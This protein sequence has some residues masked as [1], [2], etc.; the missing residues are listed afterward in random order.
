MFENINPFDLLKEEM[1]NDE[2][3]VRVNAIHRLKTVVTVMG[4]ESF[5]S[6]ILPYIESTYINTPK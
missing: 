2:V 4:S 3:A 5:K 1:D 6:Q